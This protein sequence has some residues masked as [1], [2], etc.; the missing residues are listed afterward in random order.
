LLRAFVSVK[1]R[2]Q[3]I[4]FTVFALGLAFVLTP[5]LYWSGAAVVPIKVEVRDAAT[6]AVLPGVQLALLIDGVPPPQN[7]L[8]PRAIT[9]A[10][11]RGELLGMFGAG[12][13]RSFVWSSGGIGT[14]AGIVRC[15][16]AGYQTFDAKLSRIKTYQLFGLGRSPRLSVRAAMQRTPK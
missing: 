1:R 2:T 7:A 11:G 14:N 9:G 13:S 3:F 8:K 15:D 5:S 4:A 10:D 12:G 6:G 16:L